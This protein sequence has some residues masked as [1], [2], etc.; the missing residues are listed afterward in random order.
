MMRKIEAAFLV[1]MLCTPAVLS[2]QKA[3]A[4]LQPTE[5]NRVRGTIQL[6]ATGDGVHFSGTVTGL[7]AGKHGFHIHEHGDCS[8]PDAASVGGH[9][10]PGSRPHG[11]PDASAAHAGDLGN[12]EAG[13]NG[14]ARVDIHKSGINLST[15][16]YSVLGK[17][18]V[19]HA[20]TDDSSQPAGNSGER[21]A[22]GIIK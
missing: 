11:L 3:T 9:F 4:E 18:I 17:A 14:T 1:T 6:E 8:A 7:A 19:V 21:L 15:G 10:N 13:A 16:P 2:A 22:C 20:N 12:I 5:G